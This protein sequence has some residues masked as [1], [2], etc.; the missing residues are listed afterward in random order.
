MTSSQQKDSR[1]VSREKTAFE[2]QGLT[3]HK[4]DSMTSQEKDAWYLNEKFEGAGDNFVF[5]MLQM[6][7]KLIM[8]SDS[9]QEDDN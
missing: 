4:R 3:S 2:K 5:P 1:R 8:S 6:Q 7:S 9:Q